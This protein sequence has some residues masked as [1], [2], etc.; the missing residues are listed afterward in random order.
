MP[1]TCANAPV[2]IRPYLWTRSTRVTVLLG[3]VVV[4]SLA[5]LYM[6]LMHLTTIG[7]LEANPLA[8]WLMRNFSPAA[9]IVWKLLTVCIACSIL[10][11]IRTKRIGELAAWLCVAVLIWL[12][13]R[14]NIY[15][16]SLASLSAEQLQFVTESDSPM[17]VGSPAG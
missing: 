8:R 16:E 17:W 7:M 6:T 4:L 12:M 14:W 5:D 3:I 15:A 1:D 11:S 9:M 13:A 10:A 2:L